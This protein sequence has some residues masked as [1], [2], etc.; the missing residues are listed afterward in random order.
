M[1]RKNKFD[2]TGL[3]HSG[4]LKDGEKIAF[5][6]DPSKSGVVTKQPNGEYKV[7][8]M[9]E[10][11]TLHALA[12]KLLGMDPPGHASKWFKASNGK[13]LYDLWQEDQ[14]YAEAA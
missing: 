9:K 12:Q 7:L 11:I 5:V 8:F 2:L 10:T 3:V 1:S 14:G 4:F 13:T 6:S